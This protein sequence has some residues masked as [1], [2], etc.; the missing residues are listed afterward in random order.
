MGTTAQ[1]TWN[2]GVFTIVNPHGYPWTYRVFDSRAAA[3]KYLDEARD[4]R[5]E[6]TIAHKI[7]PASVTVRVIRSKT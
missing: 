4:K 3:Q 7:M 6:A 2:N 1:T 5:G